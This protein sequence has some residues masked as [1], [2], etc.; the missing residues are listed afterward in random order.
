MLKR[1]CGNYDSKIVLTL[2]IKHTIRWW[3][4][5]LPFTYKPIIPNEPDIQLYSDSSTTG[6]GGVNET[7]QTNTEGFWS[8]DERSFHINFL[9]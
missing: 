8:E 2:E 6:W 3:L 9:E 5:N 7:F 4:Q 1:N